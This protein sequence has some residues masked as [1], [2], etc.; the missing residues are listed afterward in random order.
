MLSARTTFTTLET[1]VNGMILH[2]AVSI[3]LQTMSPGWW[4]LSQTPRPTMQSPYQDAIQATETLTS[5]SYQVVTPKKTWSPGVVTFKEHR[6]AQPQSFQLLRKE[7]VY[8]SLTDMPIMP[9]PGL[10]LTRQHYLFEKIRTYVDAK[11]QDEICP[12]PSKKLRL[13]TCAPFMYI[14]LIQWMWTDTWAF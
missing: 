9:V 5:V 1:S 12:R 14:R 3:W 8:P 10:D 7:G 4:I 11:R 13:W 2:R 6:H